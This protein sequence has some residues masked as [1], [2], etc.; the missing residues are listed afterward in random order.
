MQQTVAADELKLTLASDNGVRTVLG[1]DFADTLTAGAGTQ[2]LAGGLGDDTY[3]FAGSPSG[4]IYLDEPTV[5][6]SEQDAGFPRTQRCPRCK[7]KLEPDRT[8]DWSNRRHYV[9]SQLFM[10]A[11]VLGR[12]D[13]V[14]A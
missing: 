14:E 9:V 6:G 11:D 4:N 2:T 3:A 1:T 7:R 8:S 5:E 13:V 10:S 12:E